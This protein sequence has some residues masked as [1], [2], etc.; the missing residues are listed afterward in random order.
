[1]VIIGIINIS[2][3]EKN[4]GLFQRKQSIFPIKQKIQYKKFNIGF[5]I[6]CIFS[7]NF[8]ITKEYLARKYNVFYYL[9]LG[10]KH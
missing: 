2:I 4:S 1:V 3:F 10:C 8:Y 5:T 7:I 6:K 9:I